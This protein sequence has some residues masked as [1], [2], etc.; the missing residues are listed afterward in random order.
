MFKGTLKGRTL[1]EGSEKWGGDCKK[2]ER[3]KMF[4]MYYFFLFFVVGCLVF[5]YLYY[6]MLSNPL[7]IRIRLIFKR[8]Y[9]R[10]KR[11]KKY[12]I[13]FFLFVRKI[14]V[15]ISPRFFFLFFIVYCLLLLLYIF[16]TAGWWYIFFP[17]IIPRVLYVID[18]SFSWWVFFFFFAFSF[19]HSFIQFIF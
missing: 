10:K 13:S 6:Y 5:V 2:V 8:K 18:F 19:I 16:Y 15:S 7:S 12:I 1:C 4:N 11:N 17:F 3:K 9:P 14:C